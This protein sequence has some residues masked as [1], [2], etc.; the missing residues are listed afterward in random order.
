MLPHIIRRD[1]Q[2][3]AVELA[4]KTINKK[5][6]P[7]LSMPTGSG[8]TFVGLDIADLVLQQQDKSGCRGK[9]LVI[10]NLSPLMSQWDR[11]VEDFLGR[12][13]YAETH[14]L[15]GRRKTKQELLDNCRI[16]IAMAQTIESREYIPEGITHVIWDEAHQ[17]WF[18][19]D[20][21]K[22]VERLAP[23]AKH[24][25]LTATPH[26]LDG[27]QFGENV[28]I[29]QVSTL[30]EL[31]DNGT[32]VPFRALCIPGFKENTRSRKNLKSANKDYTSTEIEEVLESVTPEKVFSEWDKVITNGHG[33]AYRGELKYSDLPTIGVVG[34]KEKASEFCDYFA[35]RG[36]PGIVIVDKTSESDRQAAYE[37]FREGKVILWSV[38]VLTIGFDEKCAAVV[39][40]LRPTKSPAL[41]TQIVGRVLRACEGK[42]EAYFLDFTPTMSDLGRPDEILDWRDVKQTEGKV[43]NNC[44]YIC[45]SGQSICPNCG[46][47]LPREKK[48]EKGEDEGIDFFGEETNDPSL[49][50]EDDREMEEILFVDRT[51]EPPQY[52]QQLLKRAYFAKRNPGWAYHEF[53]EVKGSRPSRKWALHAVFGSEGVNIK[54]AIKYFAYLTK[55][56]EKS[57]KD[58]AWL[59]RT[60]KLEFGPLLSEKWIN[61]LKTKVKVKLI[62]W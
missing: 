17:S 54:H 57:N 26:R 48:E 8:K 36:K 19:F 40:M 43:C 31:I 10:C 42:P 13:R 29:H 58:D 15:W 32:L 37:L 27:Q 45:G 56:Q 59:W 2:Q 7:C 46:A 52:Y 41:L 30:R 55:I 6:I 53:M 18:R 47:E 61:H 12:Q 28:K 51:A 44:N 34:S 4:R 1:Y 33:E 5:L 50:E 62:S 22:I 39:L 35:S 11:S 25:L 14:Y 21:R 49:W 16:V 60:M 38:V 24:I 20:C 23:N 3:K 9:V